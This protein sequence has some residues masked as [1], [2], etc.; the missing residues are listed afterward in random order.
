MARVVANTI[1]AARQPTTVNKCN[2]I[3]KH[4]CHKLNVHII[5]PPRCQAPYSPCPRGGSPWEAALWA[6]V[7]PQSRPGGARAHTHWRG[8]GGQDQSG[9]AAVSRTRARHRVHIY[10]SLCGKW[11]WSGPTP[12]F[13]NHQHNWRDGRRTGGGEKWGIINNQWLPVP[14]C[15]ISRIPC[16]SEQHQWKCWCSGE[17]RTTVSIGVNTD[18]QYASKC[19][20][21]ENQKI[22]PQ[23]S[24]KLP[25]QCSKQEDY[26]VTP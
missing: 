17:W 23:E 22:T 7:E 26:Q 16:S 5:Y 15:R 4:Y 21:P 3:Y 8:R 20:R 10:S 1:V 12:A 6:W 11:L 19:W 2:E 13:T 18:N 24:T 25:F 9:G 14:L